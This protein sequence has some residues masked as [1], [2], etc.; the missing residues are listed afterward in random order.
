[1]EQREERRASRRALQRAPCE[2]RKQRF[3][4]HRIE[5]SEEKN[6]SLGSNMFLDSAKIGPNTRPMAR[7]KASPA[8]S[9]KAKNQKNKLP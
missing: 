3:G 1:M 5:G 2:R 7:P 4:A 6:I 9:K 8:L